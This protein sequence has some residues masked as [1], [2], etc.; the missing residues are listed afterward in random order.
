[1]SHT[2]ACFI[3]KNKFAKSFYSNPVFIDIYSQSSL[4]QRVA[5]HKFSFETGSIVYI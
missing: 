1:M 4:C 5:G 2:K 3:F